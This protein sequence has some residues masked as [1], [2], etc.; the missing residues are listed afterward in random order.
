M[1]EQVLDTG[2]T[3]LICYQCED[4]L[5]NRLIY[6]RG[7]INVECSYFKGRV[8]IT[9]DS[10]IIN[11]DKIKEIM[12]QSGFEACNK[13]GKGKIYDL[14]TILLIIVIF[15]ML[16]FKNLPSIPKAD[17]GTSYIMLFLIGLV[18]GTHCM[19]MCGGIMMSK[20]TSKKLEE[21]NIKSR[22][23]KVLLYNLGRILMASILG[24]IFGL[25]G[26]KLIFSMKAK[27]MIFTLT[28]LYIIV[29]A[30]AIWGVPLIRKIQT[31]IP[32]PCDIKKKHKSL[33]NLGPFIA[34]ILTALLPC[35]SSNSMWMIAVSS[36]S[37]T[38]GMLTM[39]FWSLGTVPFMILF[40]LFSSFLSGRKQALMIRLNIILMMSLGLNLAYMGISM[41]F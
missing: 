40:G 15:I 31:Q 16:R 29:L 12:A 7:I 10:D 18:T 21:N 23:P 30:F 4:I 25:I 11:Q 37:A 8:K 14:I 13:S 26:K 39:L 24:L 9:Y 41:M 28:G 35:A 3:N 2:V 36:G 38:K 20:T 27:S 19:V 32:S 6:V 33:K 22:L 1:S 5:K 34:G 17:N